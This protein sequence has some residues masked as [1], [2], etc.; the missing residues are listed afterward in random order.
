MVVGCFKWS[1][2]TS[3][4]DSGVDLLDGRHVSEVNP[5]TC[6]TEAANRYLSVNDLAPDIHPRSTQT[7]VKGT[8]YGR[9]VSY[10]TL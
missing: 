8:R 6:L 10:V 9:L 1:E 3:S 5:V 4:F 7:V 2:G